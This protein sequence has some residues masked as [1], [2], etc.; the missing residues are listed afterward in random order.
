[1]ADFEIGTTEVG[2]TNIEALATPLP[3]PQF[4][5][6][7]F[8]RIVN[9]GSGGT[10]GVGSP[11]ATWTFQLLTIAE[12]TMLRTFCAGASAEVFISTRID[13]DTYDVFQ[14]KMIVPNE[15]QNRWFG[16][17]KNYVVTF[18]NLVAV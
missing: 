3:L 12:Y 18:R 13:D 15:G 1:M 2:M 14:A 16:N 6:M 9:L 10:R 5:Y 8:A 17:R 7:P 4:D 11:V